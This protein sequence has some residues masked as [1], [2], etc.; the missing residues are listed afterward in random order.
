MPRRTRPAR[1]LH[2][3]DM[4]APDAVERLLAFHRVQFGDATMMA[5]AGDGGAPEGGQESTPGEEGGAN[6][7]APEPGQD[8]AANGAPEGQP[9]E[10]AEDR[11]AAEERIRKEAAKD[12]TA[13]AEANLTARL[14][15][16]LG[17]SKEE[18]DAGPDAEALARE[19]D[20]LKESAAAAR[21]EVAAVRAAARLGADPDRLLDS[22]Q[23]ATALAGI[24][25]SNAK[26][27]EDLIRSTLTAQ[28]HL[29]VDV[30]P[31]RSGAEF[32]GGGSKGAAP[33][34]LEDAVAAKYAA[35]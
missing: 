4:T 34:T 27:V 6:T 32:M 16:A 3:I 35:R 31:S 10:S 22:R 33:A 11:A 23:F 13:A 20:A 18:E 28:P 30:T 2:G 12:A 24:D 19:V 1:T 29:R 25:A 14:A 7:G 8:P 9:Q 15:K 26:A 21:A 17:L 5:E